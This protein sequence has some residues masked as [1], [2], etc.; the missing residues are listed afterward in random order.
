MTSTFQILLKASLIFGLMT[1]A[2][3][4]QVTNDP[5]KTPIEAEKDIITIG[6]KE[7]ATL[8]DFEEEAALAMDMELEPGGDRYFVNDLHGLLYTVSQSGDVTKYID[9][10]EEKWAVDLRWTV[11]ERGFTGLALHPDFNKSGAP[12]YGK[13]YMLLDSSNK[14]PTPDFTPEGGNDAHD[15][16]L[17][18][19]TAKDASAP[20][21]DGEAPRELM[22]MEQPFGNHNGGQIAFNPLATAGTAEYG[23]LYISNGDGGSGGDPMDMSQNMSS[24]FGKML[25]IDPLGTNSKNGQYGIPADNP[26]VNEGDDVLKEIYATGTRSPNRIAWDKKD[27]QMYVADIGQNTVE[28]I[29]KINSGANLGWKPWEGSFRYVSR[30]GVEAAD[31]ST[32]PD[33]IFPVAE[34]DQKDPLFQRSVASSG[35]AVYR[36]GDV[37]QL[38]DLIIFAELA[39]GEIFYVSADDQPNGGQDAIRRILLKTDGGN[40]TFLEVIQAKNEAQGRDEAMRADIRLAH[41][42]DGKLFLLN[43]RDGVIRLV[44]E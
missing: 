8:P 40:K 9:L 43:K 30:D 29:S 14:R 35:I 11:L 19:W 27:G 10:N 33:M 39:S 12:G 17:L 1:G 23:T 6:F 13:I 38:N 44:T 15:T 5:F 26:F 20:M 41:T 25:R 24:I 37:T 31:T 18:E 4:A 2:G 16:L 34:Y 28:E 3:M 32:A 36:D 42:T 22:R 7:F 21:Y